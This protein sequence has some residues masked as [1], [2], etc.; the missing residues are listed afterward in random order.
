MKR[1]KILTGLLCAA[2]VGNLVA[3]VAP[4]MMCDVSAA[5]AQTS[6]EQKKVVQTTK[7]LEQKRYNGVPGYQYKDIYATERV[8]I[9]GINVNEVVIASANPIVTRPMTKPV[10][11]VIYNTTK[12]ETEGEVTVENGKL[13]DLSL[14]NDNNYMIYAQDEEYRTPILYIWVKEGKIYNIKKISQGSDNQTVYDYP[15]VDELRMYKRDPNKVYDKLENDMRVGVSLPVYY[16]EGTGLLR[17]VNIKLVSPLE[18]LE[19]TTGENGRLRTELLEDQNYMVIVESEQWDIDSFPLVAKDKSEYGLGRYAY[20]HSSCAKVDELRLVDKNE[21][22]HSDT[23]LVSKSGDTSV[24]EGYPMWDEVQT[25]VPTQISRENPIIK[26]TLPENTTEKEEEY[27]ITPTSKKGTYT[28]LKG[29]SVTVIPA[30]QDEE[31]TNNS[32]FSAED[33]YRVK[34]V[35][36]EGVPV[37]GVEFKLT[38]DNDKTRVRNIVTNNKGVAEYKI[39]P[40]EDCG[41]TYN[42]TVADDTDWVS[43]VI[44]VNAHNFTVSEGENAVITSIDGFSVENAGDV[45]IAV[46][47]NPKYDI[48]D[49]AKMQMEKVL[50]DAEQKNE[51]DF[52]KE[53]WNAY[54][55][56]VDAA[57]AISEK[58]AGAERVTAADYQNAIQA[59]KDAEAALVKAEAPKPEPEVKKVASVKLAKTSYVYDGKVK[60][61]A[62][63]A[64]NNKGEKITSKDYTVKYAAG[65][66]NVGTYTV[67]VTF[68]GDYKGTFTKTFNINP[69]GTSLSKVKAARKSFSATWK[70]QSKQTSGYQLQYSTNKKFAKSVKT[71][72]ISKNTTVKKTVKKLSAKKTYYVRV[73]TYKTVKVG[74]K[75]VKIYSGWSAAK[76]VKTK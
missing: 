38:A 5:S 14:V 64:K 72:T 21:T 4:G 71:S 46:K 23:I 15:E 48:T 22:H 67:K 16:K 49:A 75:S 55:E 74:K 59:V 58:V 62:V 33:V 28:N 25:N 51:V 50:A 1:K 29:V 53:S 19:C 52:T 69:K 76:K 63:V 56:A 39:N 13:P 40:A 47:K 27:Q 6:I 54:K 10:K 26:V 3:G 20:N 60:K 66:K 30:S 2:V 8:T 42:V 32:A 35:D 36:A 44:L 73:R 65:C 7:E 34:A 12:Q 57:K 70:K 31:Y 41:S 61:P 18:T 24:T 11:F 68:K 37:E 17:N 45:R 9:K 43:S